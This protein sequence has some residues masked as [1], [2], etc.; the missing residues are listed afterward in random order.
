MQLAMKRILILPV[1][2][3]LLSVTACK[4][5]RLCDDGSEF[6][7][8]II[9]TLPDSCY[10]ET[11]DFP[12]EGLVIRDIGDWNA[13]MDCTPSDYDIDFETESVLGYFMET[14]GCSINADRR[15][16][17]LQVGEQITWI[18]DLEV[19]AC[20][21]CEALF[22]SYNLVV[23]PAIPNDAEVNFKAKLRD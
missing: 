11:R 17:L 14:S 12:G 20:G 2:L 5:S 3:G 22:S 7:G 19:F 1:L 21:S 16:R 13:F 8:A 18:Y 4:K 15:A 23:V 9:R 6:S 10:L